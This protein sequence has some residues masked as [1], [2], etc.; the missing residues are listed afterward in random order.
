MPIAR[1][2]AEQQR[3]DRRQ[4]NNPWEEQ[5][6][7]WEEFFEEDA[8]TA[9]EDDEDDDDDDDEDDDDDDDEDD[10]DDDDDEDDDD[11][12]DED[13][14]DDDD[15]RRALY[16]IADFYENE[17]PVMTVKP[18]V[19]KEHDER[20]RKYLRNKAYRDLGGVGSS[21]EPTVL[22]AAIFAET[23]MEDTMDTFQTLIKVHYRFDTWC[24][25]MAAVTSSRD[26]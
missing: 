11:D 6:A 21:R 19:Q 18:E 17:M 12:N 2:V 1:V 10:D 16:A 4:N 3:L 9:A 14:D 26:K 15:S 20:L 23:D 24:V 13:D 22:D 8:A 7:S 25:P 5:L